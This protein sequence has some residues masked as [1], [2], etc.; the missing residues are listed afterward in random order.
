VSRLRG[1]PRIQPLESCEAPELAAALADLDPWRTLGYSSAALTRYFTR[2]DPALYR[3]ALGVRRGTSG[4]LCVRHPWLL[5]PYLEFL[6][7]LPAHQHRGL[8]QKALRWLEEHPEWR[9][10]NVWVTVSDFNERARA[11]Y[12]GAGYCEVVALPDLVAPGR[13]EILLR[14]EIGS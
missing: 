2:P 9:P 10:R 7:I 8:G 4:V 11:F 1:E 12:R 14:K 6:A 3:Y 13:A 5:G